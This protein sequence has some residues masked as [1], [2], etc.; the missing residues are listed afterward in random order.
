VETTLCLTESSGISA[1][2]TLDRTA[3]PSYDID[4][5]CTCSATPLTLA[6]RTSPCLQPSPVSCHRG[7][8]PQCDRTHST[9][10]DLSCAWTLCPL[11]M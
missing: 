1:D 7:I 9:G 11:W 3:P 10:T 8:R 2:G 6:N 5:V 4:T